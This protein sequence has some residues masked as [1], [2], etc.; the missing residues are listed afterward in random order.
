MKKSANADATQKVSRHGGPNGPSGA[1]GCCLGPGC[2]RI[3]SGVPVAAPSIIPSRIGEVRLGAGVIRN[4]LVLSTS[5]SVSSALRDLMPLL[6]FLRISPAFWPLAG[7]VWDRLPLVGH[8][9]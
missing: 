6:K 3:G 1:G 4:R 7:A 9:A 8:L 2:L 5:G